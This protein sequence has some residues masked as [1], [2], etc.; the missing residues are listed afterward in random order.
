[1]NDHPRALLDRLDQA[2]VGQPPLPELLRA[3][4]AAKRRRRSAAALAGGVAAIVLVVAGVWALAGS[5]P[6]HADDLAVT[7]AAGT[8]YVGIGR[9]VVAVPDAWTL[10]NAWC[11]GAS[12]DVFTYPQLV[13][14]VCPASET[15]HASTMTITT[16]PAPGGERLRA[17]GRVGGHAVVDSGRSCLD[18]LPP[19]CGETFG[20]PSLDAYFTVVSGMVDAEK[21]IGAIRGSLTVLPRGQ[22]ALPS[23]VG[24]TQQQATDELKGLGLRVVVAAPLCT[25]GGDCDHLLNS[26]PNGGTIV[27]TGSA[28]TLRLGA[29]SSS[30]LPNAP[31]PLAGTWRIRA[32]VGVDGQAD[33]GSAKPDQMSLTFDEGKLGG[34]MI[35]NGLSGDYTRD[36]RDVEFTHLMATQEACGEPPLLQRLDDVRHLDM[37]NGHLYL[38]AADWQIIAELD[39]P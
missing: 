12:T 2:P 39:R 19:H 7:P 3:G 11:T 29:A 35:C 34:T 8:K 23:V 27:A 28:V 14:G 37:A 22:V 6:D 20:I 9:V 32:L 10:S 25:P 18:S 16:S 26:D 38:Y 21:V 15:P 17:A 33:L 24:E 30:T 5:G 36:G 4:H 31:T 13:D 1:M